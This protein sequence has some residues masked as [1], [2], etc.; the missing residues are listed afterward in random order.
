MSAPSQT[1]NEEGLHCIGCGYDLRRLDG[2]GVCPECG[3]PISASLAGNFLRFANP[4]WTRRVATGST[5]TLIGSMLVWLI[6]VMLAMN[7]ISRGSA[8]HVAMVTTLLGTLMMIVGVWLMTGSEPDRVGVMPGHRWRLLARL[9]T[10]IAGVGGFAL[11]A[12]AYDFPG[13]QWLFAAPL[14]SGWTTFLVPIVY[15]AAILLLICIWGWFVTLARRLPARGLAIH[16]C[17]VGLCLALSGGVFAMGIFTSQAIV[18]FGWFPGHASMPSDLLM[19]IQ[20][21][22]LFGGAGLLVILPYAWIPSLWLIVQMWQEARHAPMDPR[23]PANRMVSHPRRPAFIWSRRRV[24]LVGL[25]LATIGGYSYLHITV[26]QPAWMSWR[27]DRLIERHEANPDE[28][29]AQ[30]LGDILSGQR[31]PVDVGN[32][33]LATLV[34]ATLYVRERYPLGENV[35]ITFRRPAPVR[36]RGMVVEKQWELFF[37]GASQGGHGSR[38]GNT[39]HML[40]QIQRFRTT[41]IDTPGEHKGRA[42][43]TVTLHPRHGSGEAYQ[44]TVVTPVQISLVEPEEADRVELRSDTT[45]DEAMEGSFSTS[46]RHVSGT[47]NGRQ[48]TGGMTIS[49]ENLPANMAMK[50][51]YVDQR[52]RETDIN[53][54]HFTAMR[55]E[56]GHLNVPMGRVVHHLTPGRHRGEF[57]LRLDEEAAQRDAAFESVWDGELRFPIEFDVQ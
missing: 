51:V 18:V 53:D 27:V 1:A 5:I 16:L 8:T 57:V 34:A 43:L 39:L 36:F 7:N 9:A 19:S 17:V 11:L 21:V 23:D 6:L 35:N 56:S 30:R 25:L 26:V 44:T 12:R 41:H 14:A 31:V 47:V 2:N 22:T 28:Q 15:L 42:E 54:W 50:L 3:S 29:I 4:H 38:G 48:W 52:G 32:R 37:E 49:Y 20:R 40:P 13:L 46:D 55:G 33:A 45:L 24:A 10:V